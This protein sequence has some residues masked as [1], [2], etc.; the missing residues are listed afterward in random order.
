MMNNRH[1]M[2]A[3]A[4]VMAA[5]A[6]TTAVWMMVRAPKSSQRRLKKLR[7]SAMNAIDSAEAFIDDFSDRMR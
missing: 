1:S 5:M 6:A 4:G 7:H 2:S 3:A